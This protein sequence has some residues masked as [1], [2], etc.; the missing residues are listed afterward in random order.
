MEQQFI[1][2]VTNEIASSVHFIQ[3]LTR[4]EEYH[5]FYV[6]RF[7]AALVGHPDQS[8][9]QVVRYK[10]KLRDHSEQ[11]GIIEGLI[12]YVNLRQASL[13][14]VLKVTQSQA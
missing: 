9:V 14:S 5:R 4:L 12:N 10:R 8:A 6:D 7:E 1:L 2:W 13:V 3:Q 11:I